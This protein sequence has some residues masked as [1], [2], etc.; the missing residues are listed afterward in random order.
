MPFAHHPDLLVCEMQL[1]VAGEEPV[2]VDLQTADSMAMKVP[3]RTVYS[4]LIRFKVRNNTL[5]NLR[6]NMVLRRAGIPL[7]SRALSIGE[8]FVPQDDVYVKR[9]EDDETPGGFIFRGTYS[10]TST[11]Y[12]DDVELMKYDWTLEI[13]KKK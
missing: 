2:I 13:T 12:A 3:E 7:D 9:F 4:F 8:E 6:Y 5:R 11:F 1:D 10:V